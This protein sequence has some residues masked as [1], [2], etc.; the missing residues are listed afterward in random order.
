ML[1]KDIHI[2]SII[3]KILKK[4][5]MKIVSFAS[6]LGCDRTRIYS[7]FQNKSIDVDLLVR[8]SKILNYNFL[9]EYFE[10]DKPHKDY[11]IIAEVDNSKIEELKSNPSVKII[12]SWASV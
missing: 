11:I 12:K 7:I 9:L 1:R 2:G 8:I 5:Q 3:Q 4:R 10:N 6:E